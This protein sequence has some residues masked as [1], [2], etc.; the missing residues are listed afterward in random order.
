MRLDGSRS[1]AGQAPARSARQK[2]TSD[3]EVS[4]FGRAIRRNISNAL[5]LNSPIGEI[6]REPEG[7][8]ADFGFVGFRHDCY[9]V[10]LTV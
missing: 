1:H 3:Q 4:L 8:S 10:I 5:Q 7:V 6:F 2:T 9:E